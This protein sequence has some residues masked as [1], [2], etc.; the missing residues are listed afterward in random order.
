[1]TDIRRRIGLG[2]RHAVNVPVAWAIAC[3]L[4]RVIT[5]AD[6]TRW[7]AGALTGSEKRAVQRLRTHLAAAEREIQNLQSSLSERS[8]LMGVDTPDFKRARQES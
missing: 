5:R 1:V 7:P 6:V 2:T 4:R 8:K 3:D